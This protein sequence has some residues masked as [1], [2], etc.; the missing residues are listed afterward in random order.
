[1]SL[2]AP[3]L[4][5][6]ATVGIPSPTTNIS[7]YLFYVDLDTS[8]TQLEDANGNPINPPPPGT[9]GA[10][11]IP[12]LT[13]DSGKNIPDRLVSFEFV[14][15]V[16]AGG[17]HHFTI[18]LF[19]KT[20]VSVE[21]ALQ[22][23]VGGVLSFGYTFGGVSRVVRYFNVMW[24]DYEIDLSPYGS[25]IS[26][27]GFTLSIFNKEIV[28][29]HAWVNLD[30]T[31]MTP[32]QIVAQI[33][34][35]NG[36]ILN[37]ETPVL[38]VYEWGRSGTTKELKIYRQHQSDLEFLKELGS[39]ILSTKTGDGNYL[40][41]WDD[42]AAMTTLI[43]GT[44]K[45]QSAQ[46]GAAVVSHSYEFMSGRDGGHVISFHINLVGKTLLVQG[47][48]WTN[49]EDV[50]IYKKYWHRIDL[51]IADLYG[52]NPSII[53]TTT[54]QSKEG[55][56]KKLSKSE[57]GVTNDAILMSLRARTR[58]AAIADFVGVAATLVVLGD[59]LLKSM[60]YI[61]IHISTPEGLTHWSSGV[62]RVNTVTLTLDNSGV[63]TS[64]AE[65]WKVQAPDGSI[66]KGEP[67]DAGPISFTPPS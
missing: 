36:W 29:N 6:T 39:H 21:L 49:H 66:I 7:P 40:I 54:T 35:D 24:I 3:D 1:M 65:V 60:T 12:S 31:A 2:S 63:L 51:D 8:I 25:T 30:L 50:D 26:L 42:E 67:N 19:D 28:R 11:L 44:Q 53:D 47:T 32:E 43:F 58:F 4:V 23:S 55:L 45:F 22:N 57:P 17:G 9:K 15:E 61:N 56:I 37:M 62:Y 38:P 33:A 64:T 59:P 16:D 27:H 52:I 5:S 34:T 20:S 48:S 41:G 14:E 18:V 46:K 13:R 10:A